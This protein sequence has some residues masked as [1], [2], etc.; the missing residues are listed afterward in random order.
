MSRVYTAQD[1][2][3]IILNGGESDFES[4]DDEEIKLAM[5]KKKYQNITLMITLVQVMMSHYRH[6]ERIVDH[7]SGKMAHLYRLMLHSFPIQWNPQ[8]AK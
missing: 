1:A 6:I 3:E 5:M 4:S 8:L 2:L 7:T